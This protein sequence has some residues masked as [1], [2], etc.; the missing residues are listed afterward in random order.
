[1]KKILKQDPKAVLVFLPD[2]HITQIRTIYKG[3][4]KQLKGIVFGEY[5]LNEDLLEEDLNPSQLSHEKKMKF[6]KMFHE[7]RRKIIRLRNMLNRICVIV[8][9]DNSSLRLSGDNLPFQK[10]SYEIFE[11]NFISEPSPLPQSQEI[12]SNSI[13]MFKYDN[14]VPFSYILKLH[15]MSE[16]E[17]KGVDIDF[18]FDRISFSNSEND[19]KEVFNTRK[20]QERF[21]KNYKREKEVTNW[22][23][24]KNDSDFNELF[25]DE[26]FELEKADLMNSKI[27][28]KNRIYPLMGAWPP[29]NPLVYKGN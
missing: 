24:L 19:L 1:M 6:N 14:L 8:N 23:Y 7:H 2:S 4:T 10:S 22:N 16:L 12:I 28:S 26:D 17:K 13:S 27:S 11:N 9:N 5:V 20:F 15:S 25:Y 3:V 29:T 21:D 18:I